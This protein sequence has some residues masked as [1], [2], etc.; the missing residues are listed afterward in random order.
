MKRTRWLHPLFYLL[1]VILSVIPPSLAVTEPPHHPP[2]A[3]PA[4]RATHP[5]TKRSKHI[6]PTYVKVASRR[7]GQETAAANEVLG[8]QEQLRKASKAQPHLRCGG[9]KMYYTPLVIRRRNPSAIDE[10]EQKGEEE[11]EELGICDSSCEPISNTSGEE[12]EV[13]V[14]GVTERG[15]SRKRGRMRRG[16]GEGGQAGGQGRRRL[17]E[18]DETTTLPEDDLDP[19]VF[20]EKFPFHARTCFVRSQGQERAEDGGRKAQIVFE[21]ACLRAKGQFT[22]PKFKTWLS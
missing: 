15:G 11:E 3:D 17:Y 19:N 10:K 14:V 4:R 8:R 12:E 5:E 9:S 16:G 18:C 2:Q 13:V 6:A 22:N 21:R 20:K 1:F 7:R